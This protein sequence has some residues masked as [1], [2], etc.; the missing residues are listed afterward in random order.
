MSKSKGGEKPSEP[1]TVSELIG[2]AKRLAPGISD[3]DAR[4]LAEAANAEADPEAYVCAMCDD[5][6]AGVDDPQAT[7]QPQQ[8]SPAT[9]NA[10]EH[11]GAAEANPQPVNPAL[12]RRR[13]LAERQTNIKASDLMPGDPCPFIAGCGGTIAVYAGYRKHVY[14]SDPT[15]DNPR[16]KV[17][18]IHAVQNLHCPECGSLP[19]N[20]RVTVM[21]RHNA[22]QSV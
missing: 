10:T 9:V 11:V 7:G 1:A 8:P 4:E 14:E 21:S 5:L 18:Q 13:P 22:R 20:P 2:L 16:P 12:L 15:P 3:S 19:I 17:T 6:A